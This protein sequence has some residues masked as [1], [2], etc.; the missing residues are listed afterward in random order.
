MRRLMLI[1]LFVLIGCKRQ[2]ASPPPPPPPPAAK[3]P[4][5]GAAGDSDLRAML[6][7]LASARACDM[8]RGQFRGL[9]AAER[10]DLVTGVLWIRGCKIT[11]EGTR[12]MFRLT[13]QGWQWAAQ[14]KKKAG[15]EFSIAQYVRF[16]ADVTMAGPL[17]IAYDRGTHVVSL[18]FTPRT[19]PQVELTPLGDF[20]VDRTGVWSSIVGALGSVFASSP[21]QLAER[22]A[23]QQGTQQFEQTLADGLA[24]TINLCTGLSRFNLGRRGKGEMQPPDVGETKRVPIELHPGGVAIAGPQIAKQG[25]TIYAETTQ[26]AVRLALACADQAE[27]VAAAFIADRAP[28]PHTLLGQIDVRGRNKLK[29]KPATCPVLAIA[30]PLGDQQT[31]FAWLRLPS[32]IA[33]ATGGPLIQ[34]H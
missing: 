20:D 27:A 16:A 25:M 10:P 22:D 34:C 18:W 15:G 24:V 1:S 21:E 31:T 17:D 5:R 11:N 2:E 28:P 8:I 4:I 12:V 7:E 29:I 32:E 14:S 13:G 9:R 6:A 3:P 26:G 19:T 23:K 33:R 30:Y